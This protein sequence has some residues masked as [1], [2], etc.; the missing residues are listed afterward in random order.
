MV[1]IGMLLYAI[2]Q[3]VAIRFWTC[4][5]DEIRNCYLSITKRAQKFCT[6][7]P[8]KISKFAEGHNE[9]KRQINGR[10]HLSSGKS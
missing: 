1:Q 8:L 5:T 4:G 9:I 6:D 2:Q 10:W 7:G 3:N